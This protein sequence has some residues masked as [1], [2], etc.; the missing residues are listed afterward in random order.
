MMTRRTCFEI[1]LRWFLHN[2]AARCESWHHSLSRC[3]G[4]PRLGRTPATDCK[5]AVD[6][7]PA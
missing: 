4:L 1:S 3:V 2:S 6:S 7:N 5:E